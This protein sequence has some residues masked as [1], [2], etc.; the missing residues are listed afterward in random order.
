MLGAHKFYLERYKSGVLMLFTLG[1]FGIWAFIDFLTIL[2][3]GMRDGDNA[4]LWDWK[5][6]SPFKTVG[7]TLALLLSLTIAGHQG[8]K[9]YGDTILSGFASTGN[10][11]LI[12]LEKKDSSAELIK[13]VDSDGVTHFVNDISKVPP[14]YRNRIETNLELPIVNRVEKFGVTSY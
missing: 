6:D 9:E 14:K 7:V 13:W 11:A 3:G 10:Q 2:F 4:Q 1:G 8:S 5:V 12:D